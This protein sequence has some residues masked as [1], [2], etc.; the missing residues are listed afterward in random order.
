MYVDGKAVVRKSQLGNIIVKQFHKA[1][2]LGSRRLNY[3][4]KKKFTGLSEKAVLGVLDTNQLSR[5]LN[6]RFSNSAPITPVTS[7]HVM[8]RL[9]VD[10]IDMRRLSS[11]NKGKQSYFYILCMIDV[12]SRFTWL[13]PL[14]SKS[15]VE[16]TNVLQNV[17]DTFGFPAI[18]QHDCGSEFGST[19]KQ[20]LADN[21]VKDIS[22]SPYHPQSQGKIE[23]NNRLVK[24]KIKY[25][26][27]SSVGKQ[28][29]WV[30]NLHAYETEINDSPKAVLGWQTPFEVFFGRSKFDA[31]NNDTKKIRDRAAKATTHCN[32]MTIKRQMKKLKTPTY[33]I[34]DQVIV[35]MPV[36]TSRVSGKVVAQEGHVVKRNLK[37]FK[38]KIF[39]NKTGQLKWFS[40]RDV[41]AMSLKVQKDRLLHQAK[42]KYLIPHTRE[43][44]SAFISDEYNLEIAFNPAGDGDCQFNAVSH[45]LAQ[46]NIA[47]YSAESLR[48]MVVDHLQGHQSLGGSTS[49]ESFLVEES[50][51]EYLERMLESGTYGDHITLQAISVLFGVQI[52]VVSSISG[53]TSLVRPDGLNTFSSSLP[54]IVLGHYA[55]QQGEHFV[56]IQSSFEEIYDIILNSPQIDIEESPDIEYFERNSSKKIE[57]TNS[58]VTVKA[59]N[60]ENAKTNSNIENETDNGE[61][62]DNGATNAEI[63]DIAENE[64]EYAVLIANAKNHDENTEIN[65]NIKSE[66]GQTNANAGNN[67]SCI[68]T[69]SK[70]TSCESVKDNNEADADGTCARPRIS[71]E[72]VFSIP[73]ILEKILRHAIR[74][75]LLEA[76]KM[77]CVNRHFYHA[78]KRIRPT[79]TIYINDPLFAELKLLE[80]PARNTISV[81]KILRHAGKSSGLALNLKDQ[82]NHINW[83]RAWIDIIEQK[84]GWFI[85]LRIFWK[86]S[87]KSD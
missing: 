52:V 57:Q 81:L 26:I 34:G 62:V 12:F 5:Q 67:T 73:L 75:D 28:F 76:Q 8:A 20:F 30:R 6:V 70:A 19:F 1:K 43:S 49:W 37:Y 63:D 87:K 53:G 14:R 55:E 47:I 33:L 68:N 64:T 31:R 3:Q 84:F 45:Q 36:K 58:K 23:R 32:Q 25:D 78:V 29:S 40:V 85:I 16:V 71:E 15:S 27:L 60:A 9:Q 21:N 48:Q 72:L 44:R 69:V 22:S 83:G 42:S 17:F 54:F 86:R 74:S 65:A 77:S 66:N 56:S 41:M 51:E 7:S 50:T 13:R 80:K 59:L 18:C 82:I 61:N 79:R 35:K 11:A 38:Y 39:L 46:M 24:S 2:G 4:L 10:L